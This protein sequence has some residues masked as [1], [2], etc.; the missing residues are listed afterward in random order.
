S[1]LYDLLTRVVEIWLNQ[2][3]AFELHLKNSE[4]TNHKT[5]LLQ[6]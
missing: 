4:Q 3:I 6:F 1:K 5:L 2:E